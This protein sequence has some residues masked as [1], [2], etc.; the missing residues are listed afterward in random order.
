MATSIYRLVI[1]ICNRQHVAHNRVCGFEREGEIEYFT[2]SQIHLRERGN[3]RLGIDFCCD[4]VPTRAEVSRRHLA[5]A[6]SG[7]CLAA[8]ACWCEA[9]QS[10]QLQGDYISRRQPFDARISGQMRTEPLRSLFVGHW[11]RQS[12]ARTCVKLKG[13]S[14]GFASL[15]I[16]NPS[17]AMIRSLTQL[18]LARYRA[19]WMDQG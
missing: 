12:P 16:A 1:A 4:W 6:E 19:S 2:S 11:R 5:A 14:E 10:D 7:D 8:R 13:L 15:S 9:A 3:K 17:T 18:L